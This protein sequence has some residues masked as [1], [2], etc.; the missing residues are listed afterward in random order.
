M[1]LLKGK[2]G[3][4]GEVPGY[5]YVCPEREKYLQFVKAF[6]KLCFEV[7]D[8]RRYKMFINNFNDNYDKYYRLGMKYED[9]SKLFSELES[10]MKSTRM[11]GR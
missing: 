3:D 4:D 11:K 9:S 5:F 8:S 1:F 10:E 7:M 6:K 2:N